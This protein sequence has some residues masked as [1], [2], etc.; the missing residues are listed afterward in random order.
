VGVET[1]GFVGL[2]TFLAAEYIEPPFTNFDGD[3]RERVHQCLATG[4]RKEVELTKS[5]SN[6]FCPQVFNFHVV[7]HI[8]FTKSA[9]QI[10]R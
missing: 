3:S 8:I 7:Y 10:G 2:T 4:E 6:H 5:K 1:K 9:L